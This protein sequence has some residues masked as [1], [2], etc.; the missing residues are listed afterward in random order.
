M[1]RIKEKATVIDRILRRPFALSDVSMAQDMKVLD[2]NSIY[3]SVWICPDG[4][5]L[6]SVLANKK[7]RHHETVSS[8]DWMEQYLPK[9][10]QVEKRPWI[11][12]NGDTDLLSR[13]ELSRDLR[14]RL[15]G[16]EVAVFYYEPLFNRTTGHM[17]VPSFYDRKTPVFFPELIWLERFLNNHG[18][19]FSASVYTCDYGLADFLR[20]K[21]LHA[22]LR[23]RTWDI[24]LADVIRSLIERE[25]DRDPRFRENGYP[26]THQVSKKFICPN[27]RYEGVRELMV[28]YLWGAGFGMD[29]HT[30]FFHHHERNH[31]ISDLPFDPTGLKNWPLIQEGLRLVQ[32]RLPLTMDT[33]MNQV[34]VPSQNVM[35]DFDGVSNKRKG[36]EFH[37]WYDDS[38]LAIVNETRYGMICGEISEKALTPILYMRPFV[39]AGGPYVLRYLRELGFE[40]FSEFWD[41]SYD[42]I[43]DHKERFEAIANILE[44]LLSRPLPELSDLL[45]RMEPLLARN[46]AHLIDRLQGKLH[47][48]L[49][50]DVV[51]S[52]E[53]GAK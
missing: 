1:V 45:R 35:P 29:G 7:V 24:F 32:E 18:N 10:V 3:L 44:G 6:Y 36:Y 50:A 12:V 33:A 23:V 4:K 11:I 14:K 19:E 22:G 20:E 40:T 17:R 30:S 49:H 47:E 39:I 53:R 27:F 13:I 34:F 9:F 25:V 21:G 28:G 38:F 31:F 2:Y 48:D 43:E 42:E 52:F 46:R 37:R 51:R 8:A 15:R 16:K 5:N 26:F 41:E